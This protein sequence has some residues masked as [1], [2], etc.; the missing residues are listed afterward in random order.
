[1]KIEI[2][3]YYGGFEIIVNGTSYDFDDNE[4]ETRSHG[5]AE[6]FERVTS[7]NVSV[8]EDY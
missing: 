6:V 4:V 1:M 3:E 7:A 2:V 5:L 8:R